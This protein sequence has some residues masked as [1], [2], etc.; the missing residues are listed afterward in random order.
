[1][2]RNLDLFLSCSTDL[3]NGDSRHGFLCVSNPVSKGRGKEMWERRLIFDLASLFHLSSKKR[4]SRENEGWK[5]LT[6]GQP[7]FAPSF[8]S[9]KERQEEIVVSC[10][11]HFNF[12]KTTYDISLDCWRFF[13]TKRILSTVMR[14]HKPLKAWPVESNP[15]VITSRLWINNK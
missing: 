9:S 12:I 11:P 2:D 15:L 3:R 5:L 14:V 7:S 13:V 4:R 8:F 1:M 10:H 6:D